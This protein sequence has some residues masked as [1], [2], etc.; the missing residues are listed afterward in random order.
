MSTTLKGFPAFSVYSATKAAVRLFARS[1]T[2]DLKDR[3]IRVN[4]LSLGHIDTPILESLQQ[5]EALIQMKKGMAEETPLGRPPAVAQK[6]A[7][8]VTLGDDSTSV[9]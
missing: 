5:G 9:C 2:N 8:V 7:G 6:R 1:W 4:V 3:H